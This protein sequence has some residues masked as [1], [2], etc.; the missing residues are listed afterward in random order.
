MNVV[1]AMPTAANANA[2]SVAAGTANTAHGDRTSP[3]TRM[4][5]TNP[6]PYSVAR[7]TAQAIS[8]S[9][10]SPGPSGVASTASYVFWKLSLK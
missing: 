7:I 8:P 4:T 6:S 3:S 1:A 9:A 2:S 5:T 10:T